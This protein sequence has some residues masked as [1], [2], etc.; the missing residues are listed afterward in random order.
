L[1]QPHFKLGFHAS[2]VV[3]QFGLSGKAKI[4]QFGSV[5]F[6]TDQKNSAGFTEISR[7]SLIS[8]FSFQVSC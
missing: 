7:H 8:T 6:V 5:L 3:G 2:A 4:A 1:N